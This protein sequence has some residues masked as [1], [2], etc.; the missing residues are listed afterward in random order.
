M[1]HLP[2][3]DEIEDGKEIDESKRRAEYVQSQFPD[4]SKE[5]QLI[6][7]LILHEGDVLI[8]TMSSAFLKNKKFMLVLVFSIYQY[9]EILI[10]ALI[11]KFLVFYVIFNG[12]YHCCF[13]WCYSVFN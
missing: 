7:D 1:N 2:D 13:V 9:F 11:F 12:H 10:K 4:A 8:D 3:H 5:T 6:L